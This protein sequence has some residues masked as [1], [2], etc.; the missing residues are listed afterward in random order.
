LADIATGATS[1][2][3]AYE[4]H[5]SGLLGPVIRSALPELT[6]RDVPT[7]SVLTGTAEGPDDVADLLNRL[8]DH[9]LIATH[10]LITQETRWCDSTF[11][12]DADL[13]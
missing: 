3:D 4:F 5:V 9:R 12:S 10:I 2:T 6:V 7:H 8:A 11:Q 13:D 1:V